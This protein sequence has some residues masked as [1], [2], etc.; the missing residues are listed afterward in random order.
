MTERCALASQ[1]ANYTLGY[2]RP[3]TAIECRK[4]LSSLLC[5]VQLHL[6]HRVQVWVP[7]YKDIRLLETVQGRTTKMGKD[8]EGNVYEEQL[9]ALGLF[10]PEQRS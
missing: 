5:A 9:R 10:S 8:L 4:G 3:S 2:I 7:Q 1:R 6:Q